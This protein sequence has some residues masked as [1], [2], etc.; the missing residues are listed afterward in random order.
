LLV[1]SYHD[2]EPKTNLVVPLLT[3]PAVMSRVFVIS[4][5]SSAP[6]G[7]VASLRQRMPP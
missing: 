5:L 4:V 6:F 3:E 2:I 1:K 7:R